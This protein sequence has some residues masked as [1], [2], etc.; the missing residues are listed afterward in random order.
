MHPLAKNPAAEPF[1]AP[2]S[3][4]GQGSAGRTTGPNRPGPI[5]PDGALV[6]RRRRLSGPAGFT[7]GAAARAVGL[8]GLRAAPLPPPKI[9]VARSR[10]SAERGAVF[11]LGAAGQFDAAWTSCPAVVQVGSRY[12]I[13]YRS[14]PGG[15]AGRK[16]RIGRAVLKWKLS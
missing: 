14:E 2:R 1:S 13:G 5:P 6:P 10:G 11:E 7:A 16:V 9:T 4:V 8:Q 3:A 15:A 12:L